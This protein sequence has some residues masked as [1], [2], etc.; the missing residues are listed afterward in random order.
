MSRHRAFTWDAVRKIFGLRWPAFLFAILGGMVVATLSFHLLSIKGQWLD[1]MSNGSSQAYSLYWYQTWIQLFVMLLST[2]RNVVHKRSSL[3]VDRE[4][5][6]Y[7]ATELASKDWPFYNHP[8]TRADR[9]VYQSRNASRI[10]SLV[11]STAIEAVS[12]LTSLIYGFVL[13]LTTDIPL[14]VLCIGFSPMVP[15]M[16]L[17]GWMSSCYIKPMMTIIDAQEK[18]AQQPLMHLFAAD[19]L[20]GLKALNGVGA[21]MHRVAEASMV[22]LGRNYNMANYGLA[23]GLF[24][25][26]LTW[27]VQSFLMMMIMGYVLEDEMTIGEVTALQSQLVVMQASFNALPDFA[28][29]VWQGMGALDNV[30]SMLSAPRISEWSASSTPIGESF[31]GTFGF[32][33]LKSTTGKSLSRLLCL[34]PCRKVCGC[35]CCADKRT[36]ATTSAV[37][38]GE[39]ELAGL[40]P[41]AAGD[42][43]EDDDDD[44]DIRET[45]DGQGSQYEP[46]DLRHPLAA[47]NWS[48]EFS[49]VTLTHKEYDES[50][51]REYRYP[52]VARPGTAPA[53][54]NLSF[55]IEAGE[56]VQ[57]H[58][59]NGSG[60]STV[61]NLVLGLLRPDSGRVLINNHDLTTLVV[62]DLR[63]KIAYAPQ[64]PP[65]K[66]GAVYETVLVSDPVLSERGEHVEE[67]QLSVAM[68][69]RLTKL[70][71][72]CQDTKFPVK[73]SAP[74]PPP[75]SSTAAGTYSPPLLTTPTRLDMFLELSEPAKLTL[76]QRKG[77]SLLGALSMITLNRHP[78]LYILDEPDAGSSEALMTW[79]TT[80]L[81]SVRDLPRE[82]RP[83]LILV[84][85]GTNQLSNM[86][87]KHIQLDT[88]HDADQIPPLEKLNEQREQLEQRAAA[89]ARQALQLAAQ[90]SML[91]DRIHTLHPTHDQGP[92][93]PYVRPF[94]PRRPLQLDEKK[95]E[96]KKV[97]EKKAEEK[98]AEEKK[99]E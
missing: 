54:R 16:I 52:P 14:I 88:P 85:H 77:L 87:T 89:Y 57:I 97:E 93:N 11:T 15:L 64:I 5:N 91:R 94:F 66:P 39:S 59:G 30:A 43:G 21:V 92:I 18:D 79:C 44:E 33:G 80:V 51:S 98:K 96:E 19:N 8:E 74:A 40:L 68:L 36:P 56:W 73:L 20:A 83:T 48:I 1:A 37:A 6:Q 90:L 32:F 86:C 84:Q 69:D 82:S 22:I 99:A 58:G 70:D 3:F 60:K 7:A 53:L 10:T 55:K 38:V 50:P 34:V 46:V 45:N 24:Q 67:S 78:S 81:Q 26:A 61:L 4:F 41:G 13:L 47:K 25:N 17:N 35:C 28:M 42:D 76:G 72:F 71:R 23:V 63:T 12:V 27:S 49:A 62:H 95:A 2:F 65:F 29:R 31:G 75:S 9:L